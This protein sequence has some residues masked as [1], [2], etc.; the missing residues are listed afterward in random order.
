MSVELNV[1]PDWPLSSLG[2]D[3]ICCTSVTNGLT[4]NWYLI[5]SGDCSECALYALYLYGVFCHSCTTVI[6]L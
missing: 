5:V 3:V 1:T 6:L 4:Q 2:A